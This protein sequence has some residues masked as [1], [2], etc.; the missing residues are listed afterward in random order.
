MALQD[1]FTGPWD[2]LGELACLALDLQLKLYEEYLQDKEQRTLSQYNNPT[3]S[4]ASLFE[5]AAAKAVASIGGG[6]TE[7]LDADLEAFTSLPS[8]VLVRAF[9]ESWEHIS[10]VT[11]CGLLRRLENNPAHEARPPSRSLLDIDIDEWCV[12]R[13][14]LLPTTN[15]AP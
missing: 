6:G 1:V 3:G 4:G 14:C 12:T 5:T 10:Y 8:S 11:L 2:N 13:N 9:G 7:D 15:Q